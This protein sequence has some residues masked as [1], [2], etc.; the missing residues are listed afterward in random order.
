MAVREH[1]GL[2]VDILNLS[3]GAGIFPEE[4]KEA[5]VV[6]L[7]K[8][9]SL[10]P[11]DLA[12]YSPV[13]NLY[14]L[15]KVIEGEAAD[16]L[17]KF[18]DETSALD[19][20][21]S[22]FSSGHGTETALVALTDNLCWQLDQDMPVLLFLLDLTAVFDKADHNLLTHHLANMESHGV[23]LQWPTSFLHEWGQRMASGEGMSLRH[24][25]SSEVPQGAIL[26]P[27]LYLHVSPSPR[28]W[29]ANSQ[30]LPLQT[31]L[32][33]WRLWRGDSGRAG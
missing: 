1:G 29:W 10:E 4:L 26:P 27:M 21:Q 25:L 18:L 32:R 15:G 12:N 6:P 24:S 14:V 19:L 33:Y 28:C 20:F 30:M 9:P 7:L 13:L 2:L 31:W 3:L 23:A 16:Q 17:Q 8:K 11:T 5:V 22:S